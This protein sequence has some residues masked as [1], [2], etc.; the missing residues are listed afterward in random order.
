MA[1]SL[2][3][4]AHT[5]SRGMQ[6]RDWSFEFGWGPAPGPAPCLCPVHA[7]AQTTASPPRH[8]AGFECEVER[9]QEWVVRLQSAAEIFFSVPI[10]PPGKAGVCTAWQGG[11]WESRWGRAEALPAFPSAGEQGPR[12]WE[13]A[14]RGPV[15]RAQ[16]WNEV[17]AFA[18][19][20]RLTSPRGV[21]GL[22][23]AGPVAGR[24]QPR[25]GLT[26]LSA[27]PF[28]FSAVLIGCAAA[29]RSGRPPLIGPGRASV[30]GTRSPATWVEWRG[31]A[32][33]AAPRRMPAATRPPLP[34]THL[35]EEECASFSPTVKWAW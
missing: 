22:R 31:K 20:P 7:C 10:F 26:R 25:R 15:C 12:L 19:R 27:R 14:E 30:L 24:G 2:V 28:P 5:Q 32:C 13:R 18:H 34:W 6:I 3:T 8:F 16:P 4:S 9:R 1:L 11:L 29:C 33:L 35:L 21:S 23:L 17:F